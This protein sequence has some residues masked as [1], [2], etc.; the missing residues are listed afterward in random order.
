MISTSSIIHKSSFR[1]IVL[2]YEHNHYRQQSQNWLSKLEQLEY[3][4]S[5]ALCL[6]N[7]KRIRYGN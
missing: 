7:I 3:N 5:T 6:Y 2:Q 1:E 4:Y